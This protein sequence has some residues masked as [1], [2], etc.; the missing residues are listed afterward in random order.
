[1]DQNW[2]PNDVFGKFSVK[3]GCSRLAVIL[4]FSYFML[5]FFNKTSLIKS[6]KVQLRCNQSPFLYR[7]FRNFRFMLGCLLSFNNAIDYWSKFWNV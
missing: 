7:I 1:M 5:A 2:S 6:S 4:T 3:E